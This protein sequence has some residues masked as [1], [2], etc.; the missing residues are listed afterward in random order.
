[1]NVTTRGIKNALRSPMRSGA[2]VLMLA[3]S[4]GLILSM[5]VARSSVNA[6]IDDIKSTSG[7]TIS[8][9]PAGV[10][11]FAGG[12]DNLTATEVSTIE[13]TAHVASTVASLSDQMATADTNLT[14]SLELGSFGERQN[15]FN[16]SSSTSSTDSTS[17]ESTETSTETTHEA[18]QAKTTVTGTTDVNSVSTDGSD[19]NITSGETFDGT[20]SDLVALVGTD[21]AEK[22]SL[23]VG[24]TFTA[25]ESTV[26]VVGIY[27]TG[28][29]FQDSGLIMPLATVQSLTD[30][31]D[32]VSSIT[33][34]VD[35]SDNV[36]TTVS[37]LE[38]ALGD[39][40][41]ITSEQ[42]QAETSVSSLQSI[43]NLALAG[44]IGATV[45]GAVIV[46]LSM[47]MVVRERRREIGVIKAIGGSNRKVITQFI[48][49]ALTLTLI[50]SVIGLA[51]GVAVSGPMTTSLVSSSTSTSSTSTSTSDTSKPTG[52]PSGMIKG[53]MSQISNNFTQVTS[54]LTP[55]VFVSA[56]GIT[57]LIAIIGSAVPAWF[58]ARVR[59][60]EVLRSE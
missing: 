22:N 58:I 54:S 14:P 46:L 23:E 43:A 11:G 8:I 47:V 18:P 49:E 52:G 31:A 5:L 53:G 1:M 16:E 2:I 30:Q 50:G 21:L 35:S 37:A 55:V 34:T 38:T 51:L 15:R 13:S 27:E 32:Q 3:I 57:F 28:N 10:Q 40:A 12:G 56:I 17:T 6:K 45:A 26:T 9:S 25:Y 33:V 36:E 60:A 42:E 59:P 19:L 41:D 29:T 44:V 48:T 24:D 39:S 20:S 4:I 7:T